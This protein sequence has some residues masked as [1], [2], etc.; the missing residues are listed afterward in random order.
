MSYPYIRKYLVVKT[1][2]LVLGI[3]FGFAQ[4][5]SE[6]A[7]TN[8]AS[9]IFRTEH[10]CEKF[11]PVDELV[12]ELLVDVHRSPHFVTKL[13]IR[14]SMLGYGSKVEA[15]LRTIEK[16]EHDPFDAWPLLADIIEASNSNELNRIDEIIAGAE[17]GFSKGILQSNVVPEILLMHEKFDELMDL[18]PIGRGVMPRNLNGDD[19]IR[20][21]LKAGRYEDAIRIY[22]KHDFGYNSGKMLKALAEG[23]WDAKKM[24]LLLPVLDQEYETADEYRYEG[25][26]KLCMA[27]GFTGTE[28]IDEFECRKKK[29]KGFRYRALELF[30]SNA[31]V[32]CMFIRDKQDH[33]KCL[34]ELEEAF[35]KSGNQFTEEQMVE[36]IY[37]Y[38]AI[39][40][41]L[42]Y[43]GLIAEPRP[44]LL[45]SQVFVN[46]D[47][48]DT[49]AISGVVAGHL[50][51]GEQDKG[52]ALIKKA[53]D[54][55]LKSMN[56]RKTGI[57][58]ALAGLN[59]LVPKNIENDAVS[60]VFRSLS[61]LGT[62]ETV[63]EFTADLPS[64]AR[65]HFGIDRSRRR[66]LIEENRGDELLAILEAKPSPDSDKPQEVSSR[67]LMDLATFA[68]K[69]G[70]PELSAKLFAKSTEAYC[71]TPVDKIK[72]RDVNFEKEH[73]FFRAIEMGMFP[74]WMSN[75]LV[76][77][78]VW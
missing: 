12:D 70:D 11:M 37:S 58:G 45:P 74:S 38:S 63:D 59:D 5:V 71:K 39:L 14:L 56:E 67:E 17:E 43:W 13:A 53:A 30:D 46:S 34:N 78:S 68:K 28:S 27:G 33:D 55:K 2:V 22:F 47:L 29:T 10:L 61:H 35:K 36:D 69:A 8:S 15:W 54:A 1:L 50:L 31:Y 51:L 73:L 41:I 16:R 25:K 64:E 76:Y 23:L 66:L 3:P 19:G 75:E 26:Y 9:E 32:N 62:V 52:L 77:H 65:I 42:R 60:D 21:M 48:D 18:Y 72:K 6:A 24:E 57:A 44:D 7:E 40:V 4:G 49:R 20:K